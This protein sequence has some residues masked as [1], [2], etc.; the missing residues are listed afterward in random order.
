M[1][2]HEFIE[3]VNRLFQLLVHHFLSNFNEYDKYVIEFQ[4]FHSNIQYFSVGNI[5]NTKIKSRCVILCRNYPHAVL[6]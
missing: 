2:I 5:I 1:P 4:Y 6:I 3:Y